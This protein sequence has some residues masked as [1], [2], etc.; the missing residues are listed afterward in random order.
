[1][2]RVVRVQASP[3]FGETEVNR[4][5]V[6]V[7]LFTGATVIVEVPGTPA[8]TLTLVGLALMVKSGTAVTVTVTLAA[9]L[10]LVL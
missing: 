10:V 8:F 2:L 5:T 1:M 4:L 7:K 3:V 6:P 9:A